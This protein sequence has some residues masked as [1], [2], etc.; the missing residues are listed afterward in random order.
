V[1][2]ALIHANRQTDM[3]NAL[4]KVLDNHGGSVGDSVLLEYDASRASVP[5]RSYARQLLR[6]QDFKNPKRS[7]SLMD[8]LLQFLSFR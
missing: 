8:T 5:S 3:T 6:V 2:A 1:G 4:R 7:E